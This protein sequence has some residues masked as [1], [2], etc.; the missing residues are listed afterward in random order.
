MIAF[1]IPFVLVT[2]GGLLIPL[3]HPILSEPGYT[4]KMDGLDFPLLAEI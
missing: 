2:S 1:V 4:E 3:A